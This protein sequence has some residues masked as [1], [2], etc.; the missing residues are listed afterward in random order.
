MARLSPVILIVEDEFAEVIEKAD[1]FAGRSARDRHG[2]HKA[3]A[4]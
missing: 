3:L 1:R 2:T 4:N